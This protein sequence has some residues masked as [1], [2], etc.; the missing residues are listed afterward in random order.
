MMLYN[1]ANGHRHYRLQRANGGNIRKQQMHVHTYKER[2]RG[3]Q[4]EGEERESGRQAG[5]QVAKQGRQI[6]RE[7]LNERD[8]EI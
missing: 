6:N 5:T 1:I 8:R 2:E 4:R 3:R 7:D